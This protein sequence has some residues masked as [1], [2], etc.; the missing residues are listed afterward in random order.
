MPLTRAD[1]LR[2]FDELGIATTTTDHVA[3]FTVAESRHVK[4]A[5]VGAH[6]KNLFLK[7]KKGRIFLVSAEGD[8]AIDLKAISEK[9]GASGRVSFGK[10]ELLFEL[11]GVTP[12]SVTPFGV[13]ND[14]EGRVTVVLD[15][16]LMEHEILNFHPLEN[17]ATTS[18]GRG[19]FVRFLEA[20]GHPPLIVAVS[21]GKVV[22]D[23]REA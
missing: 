15:A 5:I 20:I 9:I 22:A 8:A 13:I 18:I 17:T 3:V 2:R 16:A 10:P 14:V 4:E 12:G 21:D 6:S 19:D 7:D 23:D 1:L 11:V